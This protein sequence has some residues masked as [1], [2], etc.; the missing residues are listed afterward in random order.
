M[1]VPKATSRIATRSATPR[2]CRRDGTPSPMR[3]ARAMAGCERLLVIGGLEDARDP[4]PLLRVQDDLH[5]KGP[6]AVKGVL[7]TLA[8]Q[9]DRRPDIDPG[10]VVRQVLER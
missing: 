6:H 2:C 5:R 10:A 9:T 8:A 1:M 3:R 4:A 7:G